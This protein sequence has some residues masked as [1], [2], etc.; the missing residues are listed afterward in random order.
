MYICTTYLLIYL[1]YLFIYAKKKCKTLWC[2]SNYCSASKVF[3]FFHSWGA[4]MPTIASLI[5]L[6][7]QFSRRSNDQSERAFGR[8]YLIMGSLW[9]YQPTAR[10]GIKKRIQQLHERGRTREEP[11]SSKV[12]IV[13]KVLSH[14]VNQWFISKIQLSYGQIWATASSY[15][16]QTIVKKN[17]PSYNRLDTCSDL[18]IKQSYEEVS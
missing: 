2:C 17:E 7:C 18:P 3:S 13:L 6:M 9:L 14:Q 8:L 5:G 15:M 1:S 10:V 4:E 16:S 11:T 12:T